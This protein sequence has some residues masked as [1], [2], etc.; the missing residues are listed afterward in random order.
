MKKI[1]FLFLIW[2]ASSCQDEKQTVSLELENN[3]SSVCTAI[4]LIPDYGFEKFGEQIIKNVS[5]ESNSSSSVNVDL[6]LP[7]SDGSML[8]YALLDDLDTIKGSLGY[9]TNGKVL[10]EKFNVKI[11][12][13]AISVQ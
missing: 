8:I 6:D 12:N 7:G 13:N 9:F 1:I 4:I 10:K 2:I 11:E 5:V 3:T